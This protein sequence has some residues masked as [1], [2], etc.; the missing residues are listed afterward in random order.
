MESVE[1]LSVI[2]DPPGDPA[3]NMAKDEALADEVCRGIRPATLRIYGWNRPAVSIGRRQDPDDLS[4]DLLQK[5]LPFVRRPTGGGA[6]LHRVDELTYALAVPRHRLWARVPLHQLPG[7]LHTRL[8]EILPRFGAV[9][10]E[11]LRVTDT[12]STGP[13]S[14][15]FDAPVRG[16][17]LYQGRKAGGAALRAWRGG[18]LLQGSLQDLPFS[19]VRLGEAVHSAVEKEFFG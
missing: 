10:L 11:Q 19:S 16:D 8:R 9:S 1:A 4:A 14:L 17:L 18:F 5:G 6:V 13:F 15:C 12:D 3:A 7:L 2:S